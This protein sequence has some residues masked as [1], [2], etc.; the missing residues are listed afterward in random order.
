MGDAVIPLWRWWA[1]A[2]G[3]VVLPMIPLLLGRSSGVSDDVH[4]FAIPYYE[5][6]WSTILDGERPW[7]TSSVFAGQNVAGMGQA[8]LY[9]APNAVF[10]LF[11]PV[12]AFRWWVVGHLL[13]GATGMFAWS[14]YAWRSRPGATVSAIAYGLNGF[15]ILHLVH[16]PLVIAAAWFPWFFL[17]I[18]L[19]IRRWSVARMLV[20][21]L[22]LVGIVLSGHP[23]SLWISLVGGG[24]YTAV[25]LSRRGVGLAPWL[26][27][28][29]S[30]V[31]GLGLVAT[32]L[33]PQYLFSRT[34]ERPSL[35]PEEAFYLAAEPRHLLTSIFPHIM[36][37]GNDLPGLSVPWRGDLTYH[38]VG[39]HAGIVVVALAFIGVCVAWRDRRVVAMVLLAVFALATALGDTTPIGVLVFE[40]LPLADNFRVWS[41]HSILLN[42]AASFVAG[43]GVRALLQADA[44]R[45]LRML[46]GVGVGAAVAVAVVVLDDLGGS[47][48]DGADLVAVLLFA[49][50]CLGLLA[51]AVLIAGRE[52]R[53]AAMLVVLA[54]GVNMAVFAAGAPWFR[55]EMSVDE[56]RQ[57][58]SRSGEHVTDPYLAPGGVSRWMSDNVLYRGV[59]FVR[60]TARINGYDPLIQQ[61]F[62]DM[63]GAVWMGYM[64]DPVMWLSGWRADVLRVTTFLSTT[65]QQAQ[66]GGW[67]SVAQY[68]DG[69]VRWE[70]EPRLPEAYVVGSVETAPL[71]VI[72]DRLSDDSTD[73]TSVVYVD[74]ESLARTAFVDRRIPDRIGTVV[75]GALGD[76]GD[77]QFVVTADAPGALVVS[78]AWL[79]G[80]SATVNGRAVPVARANGL[81][82]AVP[83]EAGTS[84]IRLSFTPPGLHLGLT[85]SA[86]SAL[87]IA[88]LAVVEARSRRNPTAGRDRA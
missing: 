62:A 46:A 80:W 78:A 19:V 2:M 43:L 7:W 64:G 61:D 30:T 3:I 11:D 48:V 34:S 51:A 22:G 54:A 12:I 88:A 84:E 73:F 39:N 68:T 42:L 45:R 26:G 85:V 9:Y 63:T 27:V 24:V 36:G 87:C 40:H 60:R 33:L 82:L 21:V 71:V 29:G 41:R 15:A 17:G 77:A 35:T 86:L 50:L 28:A 53:A 52:R 23:Q 83:V 10:G 8:A 20:V 13:V 25:N 81:V 55:A 6:V 31:V 66:L 72:A 70:R 65:G 38:E 79:D 56:A 4:A 58:F 49:A 1:L 67:R 74:D 44:A 76:H 16:P 5:W 59:E 57:H 75:D 14:W 37:G 32:Q 18:D 69:L 47:R